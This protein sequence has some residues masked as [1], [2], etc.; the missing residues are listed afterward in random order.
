[1]AEDGAGMSLCSTCLAIDLLN[2]P[3]YPD[4]YILNKGSIFRPTLSLLQLWGS[5]REEEVSQFGIQFHRTFEDLLDASKDCAI[6]AAV[7]H[8]AHI[9]KSW[10]TQLSE[11]DKKDEHISKY[12]EDGSVWNMRLVKYSQDTENI[13]VISFDAE[14]NSIRLISAFR[15]CVS[16]DS[17]PLSASITGRCLRKNPTVDSISDQVGKWLRDCDREHVQLRCC[18]GERCLPTRV[19]DVGIDDKQTYIKLYEARDA[20][21]KYAALSYMWG[22]GKDHFR[23]TMA[24]LEEHKEGIITATM[25]QTFQDAV[26]MTRKL[27][28]RYLWID[29][30][31]IVQDDIADWSREAS[32]MGDV[33]SNAYIVFSVLKSSDNGV[34]FLGP[35]ETPPYASCTS[36]AAGMTAT[37]YVCAIPR[38]QACYLSSEDYVWDEP[39][40]KR[41]WTLQERWLAPRLVHFGSQQMSFECN[42]YFLCQDGTK[43]SGRYSDARKDWDTVE[44]DERALRASTEWTELVTEYSLR[45]L[46]R[47]TDKL[48]AISGIARMIAGQINDQYVAGLWRKAMIEGLSW[49]CT[50]PDQA[51]THYQAPSWSWASL[52]GP[53]SQQSF[54]NLMGDNGLEVTIASL[55]RVLDC[56]ITPKGEDPYGEVLTGS[57]KMEGLFKTIGPVDCHTETKVKLHLK[58]IPGAVSEMKFDT[59][60]SARE[61]SN[62][63]LSWFMLFQMTQMHEKPGAKL[64]MHQEG[65]VIIPTGDGSYRRLGKLRID[66]A[67][68][69]DNKLGINFETRNVVIV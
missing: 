2:I 60:E 7:L 62:A 18:V 51:A 61:A 31:C 50:E 24:S 22:Q 12:L 52:N 41:G 57:L 3:A 20:C 68:W 65:I 28:I 5:W 46:T 53:I 15:L 43:F 69:G 44:E 40:S 55:S 17:D 14:H 58:G 25:P 63:T 27:G 8:G 33:Y 35:P 30:L 21:G 49:E 11:Q 36:T 67:T 4:K 42:A 10:L 1:M 32:T 6:C 19:L 45:K 9:F 29:A 26:T 39:L 34:G 59:T 64:H 66:Y 48:P 16:D 47:G 37:L 56:V 23:T 38:T 13:L 54:G